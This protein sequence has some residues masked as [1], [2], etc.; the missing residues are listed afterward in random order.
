LNACL[1]AAAT[2]LGWK[3]LRDLLPT[4]LVNP[5]RFN[6]WERQNIEAAPHRLS[7]QR[8]L[9]P[10]GGR[11]LRRLHRE[12]FRQSLPWAGQYR[13]SDKSIGAD[14]RQFRMQVSGLLADIAH[15]VELT[16]LIAI[17]VHQRLVSIHPFPNRNRRHA[18]LIADVMIEQLEAQRIS[19]G[20]QQSPGECFG[21]ESG[22]FRRSAT[23]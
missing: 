1:P 5:C 22:V 17:C 23:S 14:W 21:S 2:P 15:Q 18:R 11:W 7:R 8:R 4:H 3:E 19:W 20:R 12:M 10:L 9:K 13:C 16:D 6:V